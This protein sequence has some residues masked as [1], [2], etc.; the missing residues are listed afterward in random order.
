MKIGAVILSGGYSTRMGG[1]KPLMKLGGQTLLQRTAQ[2][3]VSG[4]VKRV[5]VV[6][7]HRKGEVKDEVARL[8]VKGIHNKDY[9]KGMYSS[10]CAGVRQMKDVDAFF[11]LPVDIPLIRAATLTT[12]AE[13]Y[14][15]DGV[16]YPTFN[17]ER[18]HPPLISAALISPILE[19]NG[20]GG[21]KALLEKYPSREVPVWD[22]GILM[23]ADTPEDFAILEKRLLLMDVGSR[24]E[25]LALARQCM[26][27]RGREHG[28]AVADIACTIGGQLNRRGY[29][30]DM[31]LLFNGGLLHD[32]AKGEPHHEERGAEMLGTF[33]LKR[34]T[35][36]V[37]A[38]RDAVAP[39]SGKLS[40]K[41]LV[42]LADKLVRG[43]CQMPVKQRFE[44][45]L[46][47]YAKDSQ[48]CKAIRRRLLNAEDL[49]RIV[50]SCLGRSIKDVLTMEKC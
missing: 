33:G 42:C 27:K 44:E 3:F 5:V 15:S 9:D 48:A 45:K 8:G 37:A 4:G 49:E 18:G 34:L 19:G 36:I 11:I 17:G 22:Q 41:E 43:T 16:V 39:K 23:D 32:I 25:A 50:V 46:I 31:D 13:K 24:A 29:Q 40:E 10:V 30:L 35:G 2:L 26:A 28:R 21:L 1:F 7:G 38:H 6:T 14:H 12:L 20:K 47:L